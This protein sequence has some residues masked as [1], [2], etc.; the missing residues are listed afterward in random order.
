MQ[1]WQEVCSFIENSSLQNGML[2]RN[3]FSNEGDIQKCRDKMLI[4]ARL[5]NKIV[6]F[7][8][9]LA[10]KI[11]RVW[12]IIMLLFYRIRLGCTKTVSGACFKQ[13]L[14]IIK[15]LPFTMGQS[16]YINHHHVQ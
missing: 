6:R 5:T 3:M 4:N 11:N 8:I 7:H 1:L 2:L 16:E 14:K 15:K 12:Y 13:C 9:K 10:Q